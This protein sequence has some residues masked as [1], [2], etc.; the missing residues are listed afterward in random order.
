MMMYRTRLKNSFD[1]RQE[2]KQNQLQHY[3][4]EHIDTWLILKYTILHNEYF[5]FWY[6]CIFT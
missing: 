4:D 2:I 1:L 3:I 5:D 6:F